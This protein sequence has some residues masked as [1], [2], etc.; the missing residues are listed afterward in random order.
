MDELFVIVYKLADGKQIR[1][2]VT[3]EVKELIEQSYRQIRSQRRQ[4][5]RHLEKEEYEDGLAN[6]TI[7]CPHEDFANLVMRMDIYKR[8]YAA[9]EKLPE[10]QRRRLRMRFFD[11][12]TYRS[13]A[14][15]DNVSHKAAEESIIRAIKKLKNILKAD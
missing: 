11:A 6:T 14:D 2:E 4:D 10:T 1:L 7:I 12:P 9:V 5:R 13:I 3:S 15:I 8:L